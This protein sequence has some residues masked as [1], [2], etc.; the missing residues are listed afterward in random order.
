MYKIK[1]RKKYLEIRR[2]ALRKLWKDPQYREKQS[3]AQTKANLRTWKDPIIRARRIKGLKRGQ[4]ESYADSVKGRLR[5]RRIAVKHTAHFAKMSVD[6]R[7]IACAHWYQASFNT[8]NNTALELV[9]QRLLRQAEIKFCA[10]K[11]VDRFVPD[12]FV[13]PRVC[14]FV[15]GKYWHCRP[16]RV[17]S[18][19]RI[20]QNL[21]DL[22]YAVVRL[23]EDAINKDPDGCVKL[24]KRYSY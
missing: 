7:S 22:G 18:D 19:L 3:Q 5:R 2:R 9:V 23:S 15:D 16:E 14:I 17:K 6:E 24:V 8:M 12:L 10:H 13:E 20:T 1:N 21:R 11:R 4:K